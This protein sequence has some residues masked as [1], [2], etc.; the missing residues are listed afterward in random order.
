MKSHNS[1][2]WM[3]GAAG[4]MMLAGCQNPAR[5]A[6]PTLPTTTAP[7]AGKAAPNAPFPLSDM[8]LGACIFSQGVGASWQYL[9]FTNGLPVL[10]SQ[11]TGCAFCHGPDGR[12]RKI[13][14]FGVT[15]AITY[16]ALRQPRNGQ[17]PAYKTDD[18][19][20]QPMTAG[21]DEKG[22]PLD[23]AMPRWQ[24]SDDEFTALLTH[25]K[26]LASVPAARAA[27]PGS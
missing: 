25:L 5:R 23:T 18:A 24:L 22:E 2:V 13:L 9:P 19:L 12:G 14:S 1:I 3:L 26:T 4:V 15:P 10:R 17:P 20:R 11:P 16:A 8:S 27:K 6:T 21:R 7:S